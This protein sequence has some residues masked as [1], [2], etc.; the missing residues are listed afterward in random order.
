MK[1]PL[2]LNSKIIASSRLFS[3][4]S[5]EL[6]F[7]NGARRTFERLPKR[8][9]EAVIIC[10]ITSDGDVIFVREYMAGLHKYELALPKGTVDIDESLVHAANRELKEE[11]DSALIQSPIY[12]SYR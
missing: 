4:E 5:L 6:E 8:G 9:R 7:A 10:A 12:A 1:L 11:L 3:I 2:I